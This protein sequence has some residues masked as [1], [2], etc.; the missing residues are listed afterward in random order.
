[1]SG[2]TSSF[3][4]ILRRLR[5]TATLSQ[6]E[7]AE[8]AG[9]SARGISDLER[10]VRRAPHLETVR[11]LADALAL[12]PADRAALLAAARTA[13]FKDSR[14]T[15]TRPSGSA[16]LPHPLTPLV[17][18]DVESAALRALLAHE[19]VRVVTVTG[20]GGIGK[21]R[22]A[23]DV[24]T[25]MTRTFA[26]G[27][28]YLDLT[29]LTEASM[30]IPTIANAFGIYEPRGTRR[31]QV[32]ID[33]LEDK[34]LLLM[35][36]NCERVLGA[37]ADIATLLVSCPRLSVFATSHE[38][39][40]LRGERDYPLAPLPLPDLNPLP[41]VSDLATN[42]SV[43]LFA[44]CAEASDPTFTLTDENASAV[45]AICH[46]LDGLPLAI[47][48]A[49]A[50]VR[51]LPPEALL[52][53]LA[54]RL[55]LLVG[56]RRDAPARQRTLRDTIAWGYDLLSPE[57]QTLFR[58]L[59]ILVGGWTLDMAEAVVNFDGSV[60]VPQGVSSLIDKSLVRLLVSGSQPRYGML[61]TIREFAVER[62][63]GTP[64]EGAVREEHVRSMLAL[65][66]GTWWAFPERANIQDARE[67]LDQALTQPE[68]A[69]QE[70]RALALAS[71]ALSAFNQNDFTTATHLAEA[72]L[73]LGRAGGFDHQTGLALYV[74]LVVRQEE[75]DYARSIMLGE[76]AIRHFRRSGDARWLSQA[77]LDTG[78]SAYLHGE[79]ERAAILREEGF[80]LCRAAGN[81]AGLAH[82]MND[83]GVEA[84]QRGDIEEALAHFRKCLSMMLELDERVYI[85]HPLA[86]MASVL[87]SVGQVEVATRLLG[88]VAFMHETNRTFPWNTERTR[89][90]QT[91]SL[92]R[93]ALGEARFSAEF[94]AGRRWSVTEA[95]RHAL[96]AA[97]QL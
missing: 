11:L 80:A 10:G 81:L 62:L 16:R 2:R 33:T 51:M 97:D 34:H 43:A 79:A 59:G 96:A 44:L 54:S 50:R 30:V 68:H 88:A 4:E 70:A 20:P 49:A 17:G 94:A 40:R 77:L 76:E 90:E 12:D 21:T 91:A 84:T 31:F 58:R 63:E 82:A 92:A 66:S 3:G 1:M 85:A 32:L 86:S 93:A 22:L 73:E 72:S 52:A 47:E 48:L 19:H 65:A 18:R 14:D 53:R 41:P 25:A 5:A 67:W 37:A 56:G 36:D 8:R 61:E 71:A 83:L 45:A 26:D 87:A 28:V 60:D 27:T 29:P 15:P 23:I 6:E 55:P 95:A 64:D 69:S 7:L 39:L 89:D 35:L 46:R 38:A 13:P 74:L 78:T 57:E 75:G 42:A 9:L 24:A